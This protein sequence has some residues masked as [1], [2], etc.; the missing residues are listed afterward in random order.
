MMGAMLEYTFTLKYRLP[1]GANDVDT[2]LDRLGR[3]GCN[4]ALVGIG[5]VGHI[6]LEF[7]RA[8]ESLEGAFHSA[9]RDV[10]AAIPSAILV[11]ILHI[12]EVPLRLPGA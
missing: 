12:P 6:A 1:Y 3:A 9:F 7:T 2:L 5:T 4:D 10:K 11:D 8:S